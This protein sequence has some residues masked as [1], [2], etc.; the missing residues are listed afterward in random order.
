MTIL[1]NVTLKLTNKP[2]NQFYDHGQVT[3]VYVVCVWKT[4]F[5]PD[6][7]VFVSTKK[8]KSLEAMC[9]VV[10]DAHTHTH[11]YFT[12]S[13]KKFFVFRLIDSC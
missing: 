4:K 12:W 9:I 6:F 3:Y 10:P 13:K 8:K 11:T 5:A 7:F 1:D 2:K